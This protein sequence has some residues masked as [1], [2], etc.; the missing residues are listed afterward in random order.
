MTADKLVSLGLILVLV[1]PVLAITSTELAFASTGAD[2]GSGFLNILQELL[3]VIFFGLF[4]ESQSSGE[5]NQAEEVEVTIEEDWTARE[6]NSLSA[7]EKEMLNLI[8]QARA[9]AGLEP[10]QID[11]RLVKIARA[12]SRDLI[13][14][15]YFAH[16]S[17]NYGSP[18][19]MMDELAINYYLA[20]ENLAGAA[21]VELAHQ[22]LMESQDHRENILHPDFT[23]VGIGIISGGSYDK[24]YSQEFAD[25]EK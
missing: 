23:H 4:D 6:V 24:M 13:E 10:L 11:Y 19:D 9:E 12:K 16:Q 22:N 15:D 1:F 18:F 3:N 2:W 17:P 20:G 14:E 7:A 5:D 8:N 21:N 25:L